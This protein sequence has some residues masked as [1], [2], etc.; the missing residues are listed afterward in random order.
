MRNGSL[1]V[2]SATERRNRSTGAG[3]GD[4]VRAAGI[5]AVF[6]KEKGQRWRPRIVDVR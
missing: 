6:E 4:W 3:A 1:G 5:G 2:P